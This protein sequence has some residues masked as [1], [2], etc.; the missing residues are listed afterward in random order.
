MVGEY[1]SN[2]YLYWDSPLLLIEVTSELERVRPHFYGDQSALS[3]AHMKMDHLRGSDRAVRFRWMAH[4][5]WPLL[6]LIDGPPTSPTACG[7]DQTKVENS[8]VGGT[9][10][11]C[12]GSDFLKSLPSMNAAAVIL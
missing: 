6:A 12:V 11:Y 4:L 2:Q 9:E 5:A 1:L 10:R 7:V 3:A 8:S